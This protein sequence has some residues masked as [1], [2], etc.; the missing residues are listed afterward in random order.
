ML[1][2]DFTALFTPINLKLAKKILDELLQRVHPD[3]PLETSLTRELTDFSLCTYFTFDENI[4]EK[5]TGPSV[6]SLTS[7]FLGEPA[8]QPLEDIALPKI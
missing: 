3:N 5:I 4:F 1:S 8:M 7:G 2:F 6:G